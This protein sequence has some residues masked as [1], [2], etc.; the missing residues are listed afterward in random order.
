MKASLL[1]PLVFAPLLLVATGLYYPVSSTAAE[2]GAWRGQSVTEFEPDEP[3]TFGWQI[4][5][6][7]VMGGLSKGNIEMTDD[8]TMRFFGDLSLENNGGFSTVRSE[9]VDFNLS[10]DLGLLLRVKG[11]GRTYEARLDSDARY[12]S[13]PVSFAGEFKTTKGKWQEVKVPFSSFKGSFRGQNLPD[14]VFDPSQIE[15]VGILLADKNQGPFE[16]EIDWIRTYGKDQGD[17]TEQKKKTEPKKAVKKS[18]EP[19]RLIATAAADGRFT[20]LKKA[21]DAAGLTTFFQWDNPLTVFAPTD[22][23]FAKLPE[24]TLDTLLKPKNKNR[25]IAI[26]SYHVSAGNNPVADVLKA[27][28][29]QTVEG[30][31]LTV[32]FSD[33]RIRV[34]DAILLDGNVRCKDGIIHVVDSVLLPPE[35][36]PKTVVSVAKEAGAFKTLLAAV[37]AGELTDV[38]KGEGPFTVF[39]PTDE[40]F[41]SLPEGV[42]ASLLKKENRT[43]LVNLLKYHVISGRVTAG[44]ALNA[45]KAK[46]LQG[47]DVRFKVDNGLLRINDSTIQ[48]IDLDG[49]N[50]IIHVIDAV[51]IPPAIE[52][53]LNA[54]ASSDSENETSLDAAQSIAIAIEKGVPLYNGGDA[55]ACAKVYEECIDALAS[56]DQFDEPV[57]EAL[58]ATLDRGKQMQSSHQLAWHYRQAL[59]RV[60]N[61][62]S[63]SIN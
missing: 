54:N 27:G 45:G 36:E 39:A 13:W 7:G 43:A 51:L 23:A 8:G 4:V 15:R 6:D 12:R 37:E 14:A 34:N 44:D 58:K 63:Q 11:D 40:A 49:G 53:A 22:E 18:Q 24:G 21:L 10:N 59:D 41:A 5:N 19:S 26:L 1:F 17:F 16:L 55:R 42:V 57:R 46:G 28:E 35:P 38:L 61:Y 48:S 62:L 20:V 47:D 56:S 50:G 33:G 2:P 52:K 9:D 60:M 29:V 25:L 31:P 32:S 3:K 30:N